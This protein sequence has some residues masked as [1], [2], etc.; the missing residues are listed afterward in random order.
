[1][2]DATARD[3][4]REEF[5]HA[6]LGDA[7]LT[8]R[9]V[10]T[11]EG[12]ASRPSSTI[13][14]T[15]GRTAEAEGAFRF[16][17]NDRV[18]VDALADASHKAAALRCDPYSQVIV[19]IDS[20]SLLIRDPRNLRGL[21]P[22]SNLGHTLRGIQAFHALAVAPTGATLGVL[23][24]ELWLRPET[25]TKA[26]GCKNTQPFETRESYRWVTM[27]TSVQAQMQRQAPGCT[28]W[29]QLDRG[30]DTWMVIE[31]AVKQG[32][33]LTVRANQNRLIARRGADNAH[34][35][36][37]IR[38]VAPI[39]ALQVDVP[40]G[41]GRRA[42]QA[43][44]ILRSAR[45]TVP[46]PS[47]HKKHHLR[48]I[49]VVMATEKDPPPDG[50]PKIEWVLLTTRSVHNTDDAA[51]VVHAYTRRWRIEEFHRTWKSGAC[52]IESTRLRAYDHI[53]RWAIIMGAVAARIEQ[54]KFTSRSTPELPADDFYTRGEIDAVIL[55]G[56]RHWKIPYKQGQTPTMGEV[57]RWIAYL[58]GYAGS[59]NS[60]P[61]GSTVIAR[62]L[63]RIESA[64][65]LLDLQRQTPERA[66]SKK[67]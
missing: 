57:T 34:L 16:V 24:R 46:I 43:S 12:A 53:Q 35:F 18:S 5:G 39:G 7:R 62:G 22:L 27:L 9:L 19:P 63:E 1:M 41:R 32:L 40:E 10:Q 4:A 49:G 60:L 36:A 67:K 3:W 44:L 2:E 66:P 29:F 54:L 56:S 20:T 13:L 65:E 47:L 30:G 31:H 64:A 25:A 11:A 17:E 28:P 42:R 51:E 38:A 37:A 55:L 52:G 58:G 8:A 26:K 50:S 23:G 33:T 15:F 45:F 48:E 6:R 61:P 59:K 14:R 21:G